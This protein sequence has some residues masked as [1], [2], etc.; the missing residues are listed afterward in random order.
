[1]IKIN[2]AIHFFPSITPPKV[3]LLLTLVL[4]ATFFESFGVAMLYP[5]MDFM[6]KGRDFAVLSGT[7]RMWSIIGRTFDVFHLPKSFITLLAVVLAL[8]LLRQAFNLF[9]IIFSKMIAEDIFSDVRTMGFERFARADMCFYDSHGVGQLSNALTF[10]GVRAGRCISTSFNLMSGILMFLAY[11][12]LLFFLSRGMTFTAIG[13]M[14]GVALMLRFRIAKS[15]EIGRKVSRYN[16]EISSAII[17][18]LNGIR[19]VKLSATEDRELGFV[20]NLSQKIR[21]HNVAIARIQGWMEFVVDPLVILGGLLILY[22]SVEVFHM[23][24]AK[25]SVFI[26]VLLRLMPYTKDVFRSW[27]ALASYSGSFDRVKAVLEEAGNS[28]K[29]LGG[30]TKEVRLGAGIRFE[31]VSFRYGA[32]EGF[33][34]RDIDILVPAGKMT[35]LVGRSGAGKST[36][37]DLIPR[38]R[39]PDMGRILFDGQPIER[40]DLAALRRSIAFVSQDGFLFNDTIENNIRYCRPEAS[41]EQIL[42]AAE[43]AYADPF[44]R[45]FPEGYGTVAGERGSKLSGGQKQRIIL[46]R[47]LLQ[48]ATVIILDEPTSSLDSESELYIQRAM[49]G[50]RARRN[51]TMIVIAHRLSTIRRADQIVVLDNGRVVESGS[52]GELMHEDTWYADMVK[53][54]GAASGQAL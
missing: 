30:D 29:I 21:Q 43:T 6:E 7:S 8:M 39:V 33:G 12:C 45:E 36:L 27:Q 28:R 24:L 22:F 32:G 10:D 51:I 1:M 5:V 9:T 49:E 35:A 23:G 52:H 37:V 13:I 50:I 20:A 14:T 4:S 46:A 54:Q 26:F 38:L 34:L 18:R 42:R 41:R 2:E 44:I 3:L 31:D 15:E 19:F 16:E 17:E 48:E 11:A 25:T 53:M 40:F 47:A